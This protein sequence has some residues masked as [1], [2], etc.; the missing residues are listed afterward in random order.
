MEPKR[1]NV[2]KYTEMLQE[3]W[4]RELRYISN[5]QIREFLQQLPE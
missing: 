1:N 5:V 2:V 4:N 3:K